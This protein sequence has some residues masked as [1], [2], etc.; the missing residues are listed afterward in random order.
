MKDGPKP[1]NGLLELARHATLDA[2]PKLANDWGIRVIGMFAELNMVFGPIHARKVW[3]SIGRGWS[4]TGRRKGD[5]IYPHH[6]LLRLFD[7]LVAHP[8]FVG[9]TRG[10]IIRVA[11]QLEWMQMGAL[12]GNS[13]GA[14]QKRLSRL[15]Q[16]RDEAHKNHALA[17]QKMAK[18]VGEP[19]L[20]ASLPRKP[21]GLLDPD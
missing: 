19:G 2:K 18:G 14:I 8:K 9:A 16:E 20:L 12:A 4:S 11:A 3:N 5:R 13:A 7:H 10:E 21:K 6:D 15:L 1:A 17:L